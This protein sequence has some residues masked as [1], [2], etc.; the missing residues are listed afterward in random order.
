MMI[1]GSFYRNSW[2]GRATTFQWGLTGHC[3]YCWPCQN[4][5][6]HA[7]ARIDTVL[8]TVIKL[9]RRR[10][11]SASC[12]PTKVSALFCL[13]KG[14]VRWLEKYIVLSS[15]YFNSIWSILS[16]THSRSYCHDTHSM[17][18]SAVTTCYNTTGEIKYTLCLH[19]DW[20]SVYQW[21]TASLASIHSTI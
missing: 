5:W 6:R 13:A 15:W 4:P 8:A 12:P 19:K 3:V 11:Y 21:P 9:F 7:S 17:L 2:P 1:N 20:L 10:P 18:Q 14:H 16:R